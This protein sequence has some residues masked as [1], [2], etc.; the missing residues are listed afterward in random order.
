MKTSWGQKRKCVCGKSFYDMGKKEFKCPNCGAVY[1]ENTYTDATTKKLLKSIHENPDA[2]A[3]WDEDTV[4]NAELFG[5]DDD[6]PADD[7]LLN[8]EDLDVLD[9]EEDTPQKRPQRREKYDSYSEDDD[10]E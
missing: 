6:I 8:P 9:D 2:A 4:E 1:S 7:D 3:Q 5:L 10:D